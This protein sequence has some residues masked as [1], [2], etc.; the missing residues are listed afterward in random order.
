MTRKAMIGAAI[1][2][3]AALHED[4]ALLLDGDEI[5]GIVAR[6][7]V[8]EAFATEALSG[9]TL[10]PG[11]VDLQVNGG[12]GVL[13]NDQ[14][15]VEGLARIAAAHR[16]TGTSAVLPTLITDTPDK[17]AAA[18]DAVAQAMAERVEGIVG[19]HLEGPHLSLARKGAHAP[20]LIRPMTA[21]DEAVLR[22]AAMRIANLMLTVAP[23]SVTPDQISR[24]SADGVVVSL[25]H[26]D[27]DYDTAMAAF[28]AGA[29][30]VTHLF[31]AMSPLESRAPGLVGAA[32]R[33]GSVSAGLIAD[34]IHVHPATMRAALAAKNAPGGV[35]LVTD[36]MS[37]VGSDIKEFTL[38]ARRVLRRDGRL[39]LED[40]TLAGADVTMPRALSVLIGKV[41]VAP[42]QA[43]AMA[44]SVPAALLR[45][46]GSF[47][48]LTVGARWSGV[49]LMPD[50]TRA[51]RMDSR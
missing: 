1:F 34:G 44:T 6:H 45:E 7:A 19:L 26:T 13:F 37:T 21:A 51:A 33:A 30:C 10:L 46:R 36:A 8:P 42:A 41:G 28:E 22:D 14:T 24:L 38:N 31:N 12:G 17:T 32:L 27:C 35:F 2:D 40:G 29:S 4:H 49:H 16:A 50:D 25:G 48:H 11:F 5:A 20:S 23:E 3:G 43:Y 47:G 15:T 9:G 39:T 18:I